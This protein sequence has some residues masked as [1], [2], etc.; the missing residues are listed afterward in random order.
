M[1]YFTSNDL[2]PRYFFRVFLATGEF[3]PILVVDECSVHFFGKVL[4]YTKKKSHSSF[5][6]VNVLLSE[7]REATLC[8]EQLFTCR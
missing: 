6:L 7:K 3:H 5:R 2:F 4:H 8:E 1:A